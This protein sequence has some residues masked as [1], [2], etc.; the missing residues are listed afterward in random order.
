MCQEEPFA[1]PVTPITWH[2]KRSL[3]VLGIE[4][5]GFA[6][7]PPLFDTAWLLWTTLQRHVLRPRPPGSQPPRRF[8]RSLTFRK[9][10]FRRFF[11]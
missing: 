9:L 8:P 11:P 3:L 1:G 10:Y 4:A 2:P 6:L 7:A 5:H